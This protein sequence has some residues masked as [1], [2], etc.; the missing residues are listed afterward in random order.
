[1][2]VFPPIRGRK[3]SE[4]RAA[5]AALYKSLQDFTDHA[6]YFP[7]AL[8]RIDACPEARCQDNTMSLG[9]LRCH[10]GVQAAAIRW[11]RQR[12]QVHALSWHT[13]QNANAAQADPFHSR[14]IL[15]A[16]RTCMKRHALARCL[17][18]AAFGNIATVFTGT[19]IAKRMTQGERHAAQRS[20]T[21]TKAH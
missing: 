19:G 6:G 8:P 21:S 9:K 15:I 2:L 20:V 18:H 5:S 4:S 14:C 3:H 10:Y 11:A 17:V 1:M 12:T 16:C 7:H 13:H